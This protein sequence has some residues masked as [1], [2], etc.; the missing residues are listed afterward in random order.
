MVVTNEHSFKLDGMA[1]IFPKVEVDRRPKIALEGKENNLLV[2]DKC[3][4]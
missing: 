2:E 3:H 4:V 1:R